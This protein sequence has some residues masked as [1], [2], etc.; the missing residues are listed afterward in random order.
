MDTTSEIAPIGMLV[1]TIRDKQAL[2][3]APDA[4]ASIV[5]TPAKPPFEAYTKFDLDGKVSSLGKL[6]ANVT[7]EMRGDAELAMRSA[8]RRIPESNWTQLVNYIVSQEQSGAVASNI[9]VDNLNDT[10]KPVVLHYDM[11]LP[12]FLDYTAKDAKFYVPLESYRIP[13]LDADDT[14]PAMLY[15]PLTMTAHVKIV[16]PDSVTVDP[17]VSVEVKRDYAV[18][19]ANADFKDHVLS[20][21]RK[22]VLNVTELPQSRAMDL[23]AFARVIASDVQQ[24]ARATN[25]AAGSE[26]APKL[27]KTEELEEAAYNALQAR[28]FKLAA[29]LYT[30]VTEKDPKRAGAW[31]NLGRAYMAMMQ[32]DKAVSAYNKALDVNAYDEFAYNNLASAYELQQDY[33]K[34]KDAY[35][36]QIEINPLDA[37]A[38]SNLGRLLLRDG[39]N[40]EAVKELERARGIKPDDALASQQ[41]GEAYLNLGQADKAMAAFDKALENSPTPMM[42]NNV[43]Y[44][45]AKSKQK[46]DKALEYAQSAVSTTETQLRNVPKEQAEWQGRAI[47]ASLGSYWDTLGWVYFAQGDMKNAEKYMF[48]AWQHSQH[49]EV[50]DHLGQLYEKQG[51]KQKAIDYYAMALA[52]PEGVPDTRKRLETLVG[53]KQANELTAKKKKEL[54]QMRTTKLAW[55]QQQDG[56]ADVLLT[57]GRNGGVEQVQFLT[58][59]KEFSP[60]SG[61]LKAVKLPME[62]PDQTT[63][64]FVHKASLSCSKTAGCSMIVQPADARTMGAEGVTVDE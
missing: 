46:L 5:R 23:K 53:V 64:G 25:T 41:L 40:Q 16:L 52:A 18:Y 22:I 7:R 48:A 15:G 44:V 34:A 61:D 50:A 56:N 32:L 19:T 51:D 37:Y 54:A 29:D 10:S 24:Q 14:E 2:Q 4:S 13:D 36:K 55:P 43:A 12:N 60:K 6:E 28:K 45:L 11:A 38:H 39:N 58:G 8:F 59:E 21:D 33:E 27:A 17:P 49:G 63:Q 57:F 9:K 20:A 62:F 47:S 26:A 1:A 30:Q 31:N 3:I 42:W 35:R